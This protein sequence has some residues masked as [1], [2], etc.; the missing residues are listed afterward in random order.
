MMLIHI[1]DS[2]RVL[3][4][5]SKVAHRIILNFFKDRT[6][7]SQC[8]QSED[9]TFDLQV[10]PDLLCPNSNTSKWDESSNEIK[11]AFTSVETKLTY[12]S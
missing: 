11:E 1:L 5:L 4:R 3:Q 8:I 2:S 9:T 7:I 12:K 6:I 10:S